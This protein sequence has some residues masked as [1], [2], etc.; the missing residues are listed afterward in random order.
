M[1][2]KPGAAAIDEAAP[3]APAR[4]AA[5]TPAGTKAV[6]RFDNINL[7]R[8]FA[9]L[10]VVVFHVVEHSRWSDFP[11]EGLLSTFRAGWLGVDLFFTVS[12]FVI[13]YSALIL[14]RADPARFQRRY[15]ARRLTRI[16]PLYLLTL[17]LWIA[18]CWPGF[19]D[20]P[21][22][23]WARHLGSHLAFVHSFWPDTFGSIDGANWSL[24]LEMHFYLA[25]ALLVPWIARTPGWRI[26]LYGALVAWAWRAFTLT[27]YGGYDEW[28]LFT[29]TSQLPGV[30]DEFCAGIFLAKLVIERP[31]ASRGAWL[32][33]LAGAAVLGTATMSVFWRHAAYWEFPFMVL[34]WRTALGAFFLCVLAAAVR[35][36]QALASRW[37]APVNALGEVSYG[38]YLWH[39]FAVELFVHAWGME[40]MP[41][42]L[43]VLALTLALSIASWTLL[44]KPA[45]RLAR[46]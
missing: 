16:L 34:F 27:R 29:R 36:P 35:L 41:A 17:A 38:I 4:A 8:A 5:R 9:A 39:L 6:P 7:L 31:V 12:G 25:V 15:W 37:M 13:G 42:L 21:W 14:Y 26:W 24:A 44:E 43:A 33:W 20:M 22:Q 32:P 45:M 2:S 40:R 46:R 28:L 19:F 30:L 23:A 3:I 10:A 18:L 11:R 1:S